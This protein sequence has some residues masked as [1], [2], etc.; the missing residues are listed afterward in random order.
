MMPSTVERK[1]TT[2]FCADV[3]G[4][5]RLMGLDEV[6][7]LQ[8]L[9]QHREA[10]TRLIERHRGRVINTW[11]DGLIADFPS[12]VEAVHCAIEAQRELRGRN[13]GLPV[14]QRLEF[15]IG[16]NLG[17]VMVEGADLYGEGVN[18]AA[19]LQALADPGGIII[20]GS[21]YDQ[22][23][24]K[25]V[26]DYEFAGPQLVKNIADPIPTFRLRLDGVP[27]PVPRPW[28]R[29]W[30]MDQ[31][32]PTPRHPSAQLRQKRPKRR[33]WLVVSLILIGFFFS[34]NMFAN[35]EEGAQEIWFHWPSLIIAV[36]LGLGWAWRR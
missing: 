30:S 26:V 13:D 4:Y 15:R 2:I 34:M 17:D 10:M 28:W 20:S 16:I 9:K 29:L 25:L 22:V 8:I 3:E 6:G 27:D 18:V 14:E 1:L 33:R 24:G 36:V 23:R 5:T 11:G 31:V 19:R 32:Q 12:V 35:A 7:T 21:V